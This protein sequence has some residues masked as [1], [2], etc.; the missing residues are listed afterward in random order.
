MNKRYI[1]CKENNWID[2]VGNHSHEDRVSMPHQIDGQEHCV[3]SDSIFDMGES[4]AVET[5]IRR[6]KNKIQKVCGYV[7][8]SK[9]SVNGKKAQLKRLIKERIKRKK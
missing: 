8:L 1:P 3:N 4:K 6:E 9:G 7:S 5:G 2:R